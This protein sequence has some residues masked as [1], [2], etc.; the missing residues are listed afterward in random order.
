MKLGKFSGLSHQTIQLE[1]VDQNS[2]KRAQWSVDDE[3]TLLD[4]NGY[5]ILLQDTQTISVK[6]S[7]ASTALRSKI[8]RGH[9]LWSLTSIKKDRFYLRSVEVP[10]APTQINLDIGVDNRITKQLLQRSEITNDSVEAATDWLT[11]EF[12]L[13]GDIQPRLFASVYAGNQSGSFEIR[14]RE[15]TAT[16]DEV[17]GFWNLSKLT[18]TRRSGSALRILQG[19]IRFIDTT[20]AAQL[21]N[22]VHRYALEQAIN[23]HGSYMQL[24]QQY[25]DMEWVISLTNAREL[26]ALRFKDSDKGE[27]AKQWI[28]SVADEAGKLF[29]KKWGQLSN[30][31]RNAGKDFTLEV[32]RETPDWLS[33]DERIESTGFGGGSGKPWLCKFISYNSGLITLELDSDRDREPLAEGVI[34]LSMH[35]N[36]K[37]RERRQRSVDHIRQRNNPMPQ[38]HYLLEGTDIPFEQPK[39]LRRLSAAVKKRFKGEPT[40]KQKEA[41]KVAFET[42]DVALII[43][44]PGT[45]KTQVITALQTLL[46]EEL[47]DLPVQHQMLISSFQH[48]AVDNVMKQ[49][50]VFGLP[51][52]KVGGKRK[53]GSDPGSNP[54][55]AWCHEKTAVLDKTLHQLLTNEPVFEE[56]KSLQRALTVFRV[57][58]PDYQQKRGM[59]ENINRLLSLLADQFQIRLKP[60]V[61]DQWQEWS[62]ELLATSSIGNLTVNRFLIRRLRALRTTQLSFADDGILQCLRV[63]S[64][65]EQ[66]NIQ[67]DESDLLLLNT[68]SLGSGATDDQLSELKVFKKKLLEQLLPDYRPRHI[69]QVID[70][71]GCQLLDDIRSDIQN[72]IDN[73][74]SLAYLKVLDEYRS[75]LKHAPETVKRAAQDYTSVLGATCQQAAG[76]RM[77]GLKQVG[78]Q[79]QLSFDTVIVDEAARANPLDLMV[80]MAMGKRRIVL[81]GDHRQLPHLLEPNVEDELAEQFELNEVHKE[82]LRLSLFERMMQSLVEKKYPQRVVMLDTQFRMHQILGKFV[83]EQFYEKHGLDPVQSGL[84]D[85]HFQH[86]TPGY[87]GKVCG[88]FDVP[89][90]EGGS[91]RLNGSLVREAEARVIAEQARQIMEQCPDLSVGVITFYSAQVNQILKSME[92]EGL[93]EFVDGYHQIKPEWQHTLNNKGEHKERLRV[94]SVDAFQG[95][96]F[97][98]VL[99][100]MV[101]TAP[102]TIDIN[103]DTALTK[104]YGFLRLDNRL[105]VAMSRQHSL[106]IAV[107]DSGLATHPASEKAAPSLPAFYQLCRG[108]HGVIY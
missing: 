104:A 23:Q 88:W 40:D 67:L 35:G 12:I 107:G 71:T 20:V 98:I 28:F 52:I 70:E 77:T 49:S 26:G 62:G 32:M 101:R 94:G 80:P 59:V 39:K 74:H 36:R 76:D 84:P 100:S 4:E 29:Q 30:N 48:D 5:L 46:A 11:D 55:T 108:K 78:F 79:N 73:T 8:A 14:G 91:R 2:I 25:S 33:N 85:E 38:L 31:D 82:M 45:G 105:N 93:T 89:L 22:P 7:Q 19:Q 34:C 41:L 92:R 21:E 69:Q 103:D 57:S 13:S 96:E 97:D 106:L 63:L 61:L 56:I 50:N 43:G 24:W 58:T 64:G 90:A 86:A 18:K 83:S 15:W 81:V 9:T 3:V 47:K 99:L 102:G 75:A 72:T 51:A 53:Q 87:Q 95:M 27:K 42:P 54:I 37:V 10:E 60:E 68:L 1:C 66:E 16:L 6:T 65:F 17:D 44:P